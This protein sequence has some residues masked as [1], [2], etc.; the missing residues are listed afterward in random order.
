MAASGRLGSP[1]GNSEAP[2]VRAGIL[3][4]SDSCYQGTATDRSGENLKRL[5]E[6]GELF[7]AQ[8]VAKDIVPDE[9]E[10]IKKKLCIWSD[11][12]KLDL[13]LTTGGTGFS[14][15]DVTP[16]ATKSIV[17]REA[18]GM[19]VAMLSASLHITPLA[20]L[21]RPTCGTRGHTLII[22]LPGSS[23]GSEE[24]VRVACRGIP[25]AIDLLRGAHGNVKLTH[26]QLQA[27]GVTAHSPEHGQQQQEHL[28]ARRHALQ[29]GQAP[30]P[31]GTPTHS[32]SHHHGH[33]HH[34]GN[35]AHSEVPTSLVSKRARESPYPMVTVDQA[36]S[37]VLEETPILSIVTVHLADALGYYLA[38]DVH[39]S[40]P[41]PPFPAS[42][43]DG[44]AVV[45]AD[46][47]G[48]RKV[49]GESSAGDMS[50][51]PRQAV[52]GEVTV[53]SQRKV[54]YGGVSHNGGG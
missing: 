32:H 17:E 7:P 20:M 46:G 13:V 43:K 27:Q 12:L 11:N 38:E 9:I 19:T 14:P 3:T 10:E 42:I 36:V 21:S 24:C 28:L 49:M 45:V 35:H 23:K 8:V 22:N 29:E 54:K 33:A 47:R 51:K 48:V 15:R 31:P 44:Y 5:L 37:T 53:V 16:E 52:A 6:S 25:H 18:I 34:H 30:H 50:M 26:Q 2:P 4:V 41:L 39:A 1:R 40:D